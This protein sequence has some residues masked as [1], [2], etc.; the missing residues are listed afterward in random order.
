LGLE[1]DYVGFL[2][3]IFRHCFEIIDKSLQTRRGNCPL[4]L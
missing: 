3:L 1:V 2:R 4:R